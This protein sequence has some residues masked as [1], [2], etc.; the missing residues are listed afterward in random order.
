[1]VTNQLSMND[2]KYYQNY[3]L[4]VDLWELSDSDRYILDAAIWILSNKCSI[5]ECEKDFCK[6]KSQ[7][8]RDIHNKLR[9]ISY[10]LYQCVIRQ[11][12]ENKRRYFK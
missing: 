2:S 8:H 4:D 10:E 12:K 11:L 1:M 3:L 5:R 9:S 6:N 7:I